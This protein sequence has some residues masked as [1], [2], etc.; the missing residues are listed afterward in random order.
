M[1]ENH[2]GP[3][4]GMQVLT[5]AVNVPGPAA[6]ARLRGLGAS[7]VKVEPPAGDPLERFCPSWYAALCAG[8][9]VLRLDLKSPEGRE[10]LRRHLAVSDLL[11]TSSRPAALER[12]GLGPEDLLREHPRLCQVAIVG[13]PPPREEE[14]GH[15]L[16]YLAGTGLLSPPE[17]PRTLLADLAGAER[18]ASAALALLLRRERGG[19]A[20]REVVSL[21]QAASGM[22]EPLRHG[23]TAPGGLLGGGFPG[24]GLYRAADGWV[25]VA[26]LEEHFWR[27]LL[28]GLGLPEGAGREEISARLAQRGC[29]EWEQWALERDLPLAAVRE[30]P[31]RGEEE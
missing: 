18:A 25:A 21:A 8:Q 16:T 28:A 10:E 2:P 23:L 22:A 11:L 26:A 12:L 17:P 9:K 5:L 15:D 20:G 7:A 4:Q 29:R 13:Y 1:A 6:A 31:P 24:Y 27:G 14:P 30:A 3:L 19:G